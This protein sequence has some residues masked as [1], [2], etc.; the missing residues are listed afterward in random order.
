KKLGGSQT[1]ADLLKT[2]MNLYKNQEPPFDD[3]FIASANTITNWWMSIEI[4]R[5][6]DHIKNLA[7]KIHSILPYNA[8]FENAKSELNYIDLNLRQEDF[9]SIFNKISSS[10]EDGT[11]LFSEEDLFSIQ[12]ESTEE[13]IEDM[14]DLLEENLAKE[15]SINLEIEN[16]INLS[17][18]LK[19]SESSSI[20]EEIIHRDKN[21]DVNE[22]L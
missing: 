9:L 3:K 20:I 10:I 12:E 4:K 8:T 13:P 21:F 19:L 14:E 16:L 22:L 7:L 18:K 17:F 15:N 11:D 5:H 2:Q 6:E 1:S